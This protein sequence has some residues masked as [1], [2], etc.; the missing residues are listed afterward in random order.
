MERLTYETI[1]KQGYD[2]FLLEQGAEKII[3]FGEGNFLRGFADHFIDIL[4][5]KEGFSGKVAV[6]QPI[7]KGRVTDINCQQGLYTLYLQ[8]F[9]GGQAKKEKRIIS[10]ISRG[11][12]PYQDYEGFLSLAR[13]D[14]VA[15][16][17][18]NTTEAGI[19][20][21]ETCRFE[22]RPQSSF[23]GKLTRLLFE[24]F[25]QGDRKKG[26]I[27][28]SCELID[29]NGSKLKECV[30]K[31]SKA[32]GLGDAFLD[33]IQQENLFCSTLVDRIVTGTPADLER[34]NQKNGYEDRLL[35]TAETFG[36]W[37]IEGPPSLT[38][39]LPF[40]KAVLP[41]II[42]RDH[43]PYKKRKVR[44]LNGAHTCMVPVASLAGQKIVR[45]SMED[46]DISCFIKGL[47]YEE[48]IPTIDLPKEESDRFA[49]DVL[50][51]FA[52]PF[53]DHKLEDIALNSVSKW[54]A[55]VKPAMK[56]YFHQKGVLPKRMVFALAALIVFYQTGNIRDDKAVVDFFSSKR[57]DDNIAAELLQQ[58]DF[59]QEDLSRIKGLVL[60]VSQYI[61]AIK[62][63]GMRQ[64]LADFLRRTSS[65]MD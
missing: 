49:A 34:E 7:E 21:D 36:L 33:W 30:L 48:V 23:P 4:N 2:G 31:H 64:A 52:N 43:G 17:I 28:L 6:V 20:Y 16:I 26:F 5:E 58:E 54:T 63:A 46:E 11:I 22:D 35:N 65:E 32:W 38:E 14:S 13:Q 57:N 50:D 37:V 18:S 39:K 59:F 51:R 62:K 56:D 25:S 55:R 15:Y 24:R 19:V 61:E 12:D 10:C 3:Q 47:V 8:G 53:I 41:V 60:Q 40:A 42:T 1:K 44:I 29:N 9:E 45:E 27:I